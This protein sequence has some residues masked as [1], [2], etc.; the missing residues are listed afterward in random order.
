MSIRAEEEITLTR[1]DD[2][3][4]GATG[5]QGPQGEQGPKGEQGPQ[6]IQGETGATGPQGPQGE[7]GIQGP[8]GEKG[9]QGPQGETGATGPQGP[10]GE[11]GEHGIQGETG[12][13]GPQGKQGIQGETGATGPQGPQGIRGETGPQGPAGATGKGVSSVT[14]QWAKGTASAALASSWSEAQPTLDTD[15]PKLWYRQKIMW[16]DNTT[17]YSP[18]SAGILA[19]VVN[20][21]MYFRNS[22]ANSGY[23]SINGSHIEGGTIKLGGGASLGDGD[24]KVFSASDLVNPLVHIGRNVN[25]SGLDGMFA[26]AGLIGG[27]NINNN[28]LSGVDTGPYNVWRTRHLPIQIEHI[29]KYADQAGPCTYRQCTADDGYDAETYMYCEYDSESGEY[30]GCF[31][32]PTEA[33]YYA[34]PGHYYVPV[35]TD[36]RAA[37]AQL[38][39][40]VVRVCDGILKMDPTDTNDWY[41]C[42]DLD[43][44][45]QQAELASAYLNMMYTEFGENN[46]YDSKTVSLSSHPL[47]EFGI[48]MTK[49][50]NDGEEFS[51]A[52]AEMGPEYISVRGDRGETYITQGDIQI[53]GVSIFDKIFPVGYV[54]ISADSTSP[55]DL[56]G[57]EWVR[58]QGRFL[59]AAGTA[60]QDSSITYGAL[61]TGGNKNA[62]IPYHRH[63][64]GNIW[65]NGS[66][67]SS[68]YVMSSSRKLQTRYTSYAG[69]SGNT[70]NANM[71][72]YLAVYMWRRT[73]LASD[74]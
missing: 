9:I 56:F 13:R 23:T 59:L 50:S 41:E 57:G 63:D 31:P 71:P 18:S 73:K 40:G 70:T 52:A 20:D 69:T 49:E 43:K 72:P 15:Y 28:S 66:G 17:T 74:M 10:Q 24:L 11:Q 29:S 42:M 19:T 58:I 55:A 32:Q 26:K 30:V 45:I 21:L 60:P 35:Y 1:V 37:L 61:A 65:S 64:I 38:V 5:P 54:Y 51:Y 48:Q 27:L 68:A 16:T 3:Q 44:E 33:E 22:V 39:S 46:T 25:G 12:P 62:I 34:N 6:G 8:Q 7:Q 14:E 2:G 53:D 36:Y 47:E 4:A 67:S